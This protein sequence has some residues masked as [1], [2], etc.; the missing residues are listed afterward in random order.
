VLARVL[1]SGRGLAPPARERLHSA[2][3]SQR[4]LEGGRCPAGG[5]FRTLYP[6]RCRIRV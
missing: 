4:V 3:Y 2:A 6:R 5:D 1:G